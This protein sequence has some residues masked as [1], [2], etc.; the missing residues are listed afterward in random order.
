MERT[1][2]TPRG[3]LRAVARDIEM[4][5]HA[6]LIGGRAARA[7]TAGLRAIAGR[8]GA[9]LDRP[10]NRDEMWVLHE[11]ASTVLDGDRRTAES[12]RGVLGNYLLDTAHVPDVRGDAP[13]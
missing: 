8:L 12:L 13:A 11:E 10:I 3:V 6:G 7:R 5:H 2:C 9:D 4:H 1:P